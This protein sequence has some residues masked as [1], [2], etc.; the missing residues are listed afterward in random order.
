M[1]SPKISLE[2]NHGP[3]SAQLYNDSSL[4]ECLVLSNATSDDAP[5][6]RIQSSCVFSESFGSGD[7]DCALQLNASLE[8]VAKQGGYLFYLYDEG[9][10]AGLRTKFEGIFLEQTEN[11]SSAEAYK[12]LGVETDARNY[13][14]AI[15][16][17]QAVGLPSSIRMASNNPTKE[18]LIALAGFTIIESVKLD[19]EVT[20]RI[21]DYLKS[22]SKHL[23]HRER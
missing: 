3:L 12:K 23:G 9:R 1:L 16:A 17:M 18:K 14:T 15:E 10:G 8:V 19:Y 4:K 13:S 21:A 11:M 22:K 5:F 6:V 7:C 2:T 20:D